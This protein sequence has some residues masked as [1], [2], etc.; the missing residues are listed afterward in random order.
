MTYMPLSLCNGFL[1]LLICFIESNIIGIVVTKA[2]LTNEF[3]K[4]PIPEPPS[5]PDPIRIELGFGLIP[6]VDKGR[7]AEFLEL[8]KKTR[9]QLIEELKIEIPKVRIID[10]ILLEINEYSI[11]IRGT[12]AGRWMLKPDC[13]LCIGSGGVR[14]K[15]PGEKVCEPVSGLPAIWASADKREEAERL[16]Y[17]VADPEA[18]IVSHLRDIIIQRAGEFREDFVTGPC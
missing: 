10:N 4:E 17:T 16:G 9:L 7:G 18:V 11:F 3:Y 5:P 1:A 13:L 14:K 8:L 12:E 15:L 6:L 2:V